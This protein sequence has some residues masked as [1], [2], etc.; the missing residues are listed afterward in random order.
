MTMTTLG[1][2]PKP[3]TPPKPPK[4]PK[5]PTFT[6]P[7][8]PRPQNTLRKL[9]SFQASAPKSPTVVA[10][11]K[12]TPPKPPTNL[13]MPP[14]GAAPKLQTPPPTPQPAAQPQQNSFMGSALKGMIPW[15]TVL[16]GGLPMIA[17]LSGLLR[18]QNTLA[19]LFEGPDN[20][21]K[22]AAFEFGRRA[23]RLESKPRG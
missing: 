7:K 15:K 16:R 1:T 13:Q 14:Q 20:S 19:P 22:T 5:Q 18:G 2:V 3:A 4:P 17:G 10:G 21:A 8:P 23:V 12:T 11:M 6:P 9:S